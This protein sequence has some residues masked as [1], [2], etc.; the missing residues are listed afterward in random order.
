MTPEANPP[1]RDERVNAILADWLR[2]A[3]AGQAPRRD[4][5]LARHPDLADELRSF[6]ADHDAAAGLA[7]P[8]VTPEL[9]LRGVT[10]ADPPSPQHGPGRVPSPPS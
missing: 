6:F 5:L 2:A 7:R 4:E 10:L 1:S 9:R 8:Q 3:D